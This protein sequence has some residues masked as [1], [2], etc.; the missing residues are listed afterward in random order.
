MPEEVK[1][2]LTQDIPLVDIPVDQN[3]TPDPV[4]KNSVYKFMKANN[5]TS[6]SENDFLKKYSTPD[7][8]KEI[9]SFMVA[10][11]LTTLKDND[12]YGKY[13]Q[14]EPTPVL[15]GGDL[16]KKVQTTDSGKVNY[17]DSKAGSE[18]L[19]NG[20]NNNIINWI[21]GN[22]V[23]KDNKEV[24]PEQPIIS[25]N[26]SLSRLGDLMKG[27]KQRGIKRKFGYDV[28]YAGEID[29][30]TGMPVAELRKL[31]RQSSSTGPVT[32]DYRG[33]IVQDLVEYNAPGGLDYVATLPS[34]E[35]VKMTS[36]VPIPRE[37]I[38][39]VHKREVGEA[40]INT[41][42]K[43]YK[44]KGQKFDKNSLE[45]KQQIEDYINKE[46]S[47]DLVSVYGNFDQK[48]YLVR[49]RGFW[50]SGT[51][52]LV[53]SAVDPVLY[54]DI[55]TTF[56]PSDLADKLDARIEAEGN[57]PESA[58]NSWGRYGEMAGGLPKMALLLSTPFAGEAALV[59]DVYQNG[60]ARQ[61]MIL[62]QKGLNEGLD[63]IEAA[64]R[65]MSA[66]PAV[67]A[68]EAIVNLAMARGVGNFGR[69][70]SKIGQSSSEAIASN[71]TKD[72]G[73]SIIPEAAK[74]TF[75]NALKNSA[76]STAAITAMGAGSGAAE[77]LVERQSG[78]KVS[79]Q[80]IINKALEGGKDYFFMDLAFKALHG[81]ANAPAYLRS[82]SKNLLNEIPTEILEA[83]AETIP[84]GGE[85]LQKLGNF[86][87]AKNQVKGLVSD[88]KIASVA[89]LTEKINNINKT[90]D[91]L[92]KRKNS[93]TEAL[94][95][96]VDNLIKEQQEQ[97]NYYNEQVKKVVESKDPTGISEELDEL[98]GEK[99]GTS[100]LDLP[101]EKLPITE[102]GKTPETKEESVNK[103]IKIFVPKIED[104]NFEITNWDKN[105]VNQI[106]NNPIEFIDNLLDVNK[107]ELEEN[108]QTPN[109]EF[110]NNLTKKLEDVKQNYLNAEK[111]EGKQEVVTSEKGIK[112]TDIEA[113]KA[114]IERRRQE[115]LSKLPNKGN[116][117]GDLI[118]V[119][120][121]EADAIDAKYDKELK[122]LESGKAEVK[123]TEEIPEVTVEGLT[124]GY[125]VLSGK[126][127]VGDIRQEANEA[128]IAGKDTFTKETVKDGKKTFTLVDTTTTD[129]V[130]RPAY[131][132][133]SIT[134]PEGTKLTIE[135]VMPNLE[136]GLK[137]EKIEPIKTV[138]KAEV[139][140]TD[141]GKIENT[142]KQEAINK[143]NKQLQSTIEKNSREWQEANIDKEEHPLIVGDKLAEGVII[144]IGEV[145]D[146]RENNNGKRLGKG[147]PEGGV[148]V[149]TSI[150]D[151][152]NLNKQGKVDVGIFNSKEEANKW[153]A[154]RDARVKQSYENKLS[155]IDAKYAETATLEGGKKENI[156]I[157]NIVDEKGNI[158][159]YSLKAAIVDTPALI[160]VNE[161]TIENTVGHL[162]QIADKVNDKEL[163]D[164]VT[165][166]ED[167][168]NM[169][170]SL[171]NMEEGK[172]NEFLSNQ[173]NFYS[174]KKPPSEV[175]KRLDDWAKVLKGNTAKNNAERLL[176]EQYQQVLGEIQKRFIDEKQQPNRPKLLEAPVEKEV[177]KSSQ[178][179]TVDIENGKLI[180]K[181]KK[182]EVLSDRASKKAIEEYAENF[183]YSKGEKAPE[184]P[185]EI[186]NSRDAAKYV[187]EESSNPI[188]IAEIYASE[189][190]L[191]KESNPKFQAI[192]E[193]G[194]G[195]IK[196]SSY[197]NLGDPNKIEKSMYLKIFSEERGTPIDVLAKS[198]SDKYEGLSIE[199]QDIVDYIEKYSKGDKGA[200]EFKESDIAL[201]A[202]DK[203]NKLT[204]LDLN[205]ELAN[206]I[207]DNKLGKA[208]KEQLDIIKE[209]YETAK[210][211][212]DA[213]WAEYKKTDGFTKESNIGEANK[214]EAAKEPQKKLEQ[215]YKDLTN[216]EKRQ[217]IN[218]KFEELLK[219]LKIE[220]ICPTD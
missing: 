27:F 195:R 147:V 76:K 62:Y 90:I 207:I 85:I 78:Y 128:R 88:E 179:Y 2:N 91:D 115:D 36:T 12:F 58:P 173:E 21:K 158:N 176:K 23:K 110:L 101:K 37:V 72:V 41:L 84:D 1:Q 29:E 202:A 193:Y 120:S 126:N 92:N 188:E 4:P 38:K 131:K 209:D 180:V 6:L 162:R 134:L 141:V 185:S 70:V 138:E 219:E 94:K 129:S 66:A 67:A 127:V 59:T 143:A 140:P 83:H 56:N 186:T 212:E 30:K 118:T 46:N 137:G 151:L 123:P 177:F 178:G 5:L 63:R 73:K 142:E 106:K 95:P 148:P 28:N 75:K 93:S 159:T 61:K 47:G 71:L 191:P 172:R 203:F 175:L 198:I 98:T 152:G 163:N 89:G 133:A 220:K 184:V 45:G 34:G 204:G 50:E 82:A 96:I 183:D 54:T 40:A 43:L 192:A 105:L 196:T 168:S 144:K 64:R 215:A 77:G 20:S 109:A 136:A 135:D 22:P 24:K 3:Y 190:L 11:N 17:T 210:Q 160:N 167:A 107:R 181:D 44:E 156:N 130:G 194:L 52:Q 117:E 187:I 216:I 174:D 116:I 121:N 164:T 132:S 108:P 26:K 217:I 74:N 86:S 154:D 124:E 170:L 201:Q 48:P 199:P 42:D 81:A 189:D 157:K 155:K 161:K 214:P 206:N 114:D 51:K 208:N 112:P 97:L 60:M 16:K 18:I 113:Q 39:Q 197:K 182:G 166:L 102:Y 145:V 200:L 19:S 14:T 149:V 79:N 55:N 99:A 104:P 31:Q 35:K 103:L 13:F 33:N 119:K 122:D 87:E 111:A 57:I 49:G 139:K 146:Y 150:E 10:N 7:K 213:Y 65:A 80:D 32:T 53:Q 205:S 68:P 125:K 165:Y 9:H 218:S 15:D 211:L 69:D 100:N 8:A 25:D 153:L 169:L 171:K